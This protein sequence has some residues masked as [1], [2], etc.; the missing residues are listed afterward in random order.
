MAST[1]ERLKA[2]V[3]EN[4]EV[5]GQPLSVPEDLNISLME[6][7]V[8]STDIVALARLI[9]QEFNVTFTPEDCAS[10]NSLRA[11]ADFIDAKA[12]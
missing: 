5:D 4:I 7:G 3:G 1:D 9:A 12:A 8:P 10:L 11:V 2:I 6:S